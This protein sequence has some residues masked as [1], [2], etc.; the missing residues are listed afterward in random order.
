MKTCHADRAARV[1]ATALAL[2]RH[3]WRA[4]LAALALLSAAVQ[5]PADA[6]PRQV[7]AFDASA[8]PALQ[9]GLKQPAVVVFSTTDCAHCPAVLAQLHQ[10]IGRRRAALIA[11]VMD[12]VPGQDDAALKADAHYR[13]A[14]RLFAFDGQ[15]PALRHAV[16]PRWRGVTPYVV[17]LTPGSPPKAVTG[18]PP[19]AHVEAW[20][21]APTRDAR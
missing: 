2:L 18:P 10:H 21:R 9:A 13:H 12:L 14:D 1:H 6:A 7:E 15:A 19:A 8:W 16:D 11:V 3:R 20:L 4:W 17:F 5:L